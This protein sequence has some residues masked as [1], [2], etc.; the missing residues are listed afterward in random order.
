MRIVQDF[1]NEDLKNKLNDFY[2][3]FCNGFEFENFL[4]P[5]LEN[6]GLKDVVVTNKTGD[7]GVD[8]YATN[9]GLTDLGDAAKV[10]YKIQA[11]RYKPSTTI[12]PEKIDA[13]RGVMGT[14][15]KGLFITTGKVSDKAKDVAI[16]KDPNRPVYVIDGLD[17]V[18]ICIEKQIGFSYMPIFSKSALDDF[19][20]KEE[21]VETQTADEN[22]YNYIPKKITENDIR[23]HI[24]SVPSLIVKEINNNK[25]KHNM[26]VIINEIDEFDVVFC[27]SRNY[28]SSITNILRKYGLLHDDRTLSEKNTLWHIDKQTQKIYIKI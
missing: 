28:I 8:L 5:F 24:I 10:Y 22:Q 25:N 1:S 20:N 6:M 17:L 11:K 21:N 27:P 13:L 9:Y 26:K 15:E 3:Y 16:T 2:N 14:N 12:S 19:T 4:K 23:R 7:G 18:R